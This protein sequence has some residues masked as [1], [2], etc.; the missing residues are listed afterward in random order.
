M[1]LT[2][3]SP[4]TAATDTTRAMKH[5]YDRILITG[6]GGMLGRALAEALRR[7]GLAPDVRDR[8]AF[9]ISN[10]RQLAAVVGEF[11]PTLVL[12]CAAYTKVDNAEDEPDK[13]NDVNGRAVGDLAEQCAVAGAKLVHFSTDFVFDGSARRPYQ[14]TDRPNPIS[15]YGR[16]KLLGEQLA[17]SRG[18]RDALV[19]RTAWLYGLGG[20]NFP[21]VIAERA[22]QGQPLK[23]VN[24]ETGSPT[25]ADDLADTTLAMLDRGAAGVWHV[26]NSGQVSRF[27]YARAVLD[28]FGVRTELTPITTAE[29]FQIRPKQAKRPAYSV[30]DV[31]PVAKFTGRPMRPWREA[32]NDFA[33]AVARRGSF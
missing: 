8:A 25:Y 13:A 26:T 14:S 31:E 1:T 21:R 20:M 6:G 27:E 3:S 28:A 17:L 10:P 2:S 4:K 16:S 24:D 22:R 15:A 32:L 7:R 5:L 19:I 30:L 12:N 18:T 9:D 11:R 33:A 23:V 29:W